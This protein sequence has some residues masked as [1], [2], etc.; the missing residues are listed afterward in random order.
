MN[1]DNDT[2]S[3]GD[4]SLFSQIRGFFKPKDLDDLMLDEIL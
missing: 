4:G 2:D 1:E 3:E